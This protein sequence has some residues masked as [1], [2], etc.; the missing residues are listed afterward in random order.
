MPAERKTYSFSPEVRRLLEGSKLAFAAFQ[1]VDGQYVTLL[2]SDGAC[3]IFELGREE[4]MR[5]L[6]NKSYR[7]MHPNDAGKLMETSRKFS[8]AEELSVIFRVMR[9]GSYHPVLF[10]ERPQTMEDGSVLY[11]VSYTDMDEMKEGNVREYLAYQ[12]RQSQ[13]L[14]Q[15]DVT[16]LPNINYFQN[17]A[18]GTLRE[19]LDRGQQPLVIFL[20][21]QGMHSYNDRFGYEKGDLLLK[22]TAEIIRDSFPGDFCVRHTEDHIVLITVKKDYEE[23]INEVRRKVSIYASGFAD[24]VVDV[25]AG[26]YRYTDS[27]Q[28]CVAAVD[29]ARRA[30]DYIHDCPGVFICQYS[31]QVRDS[32]NRKDYVISHYREAMKKGWIRV[33][34]QPLISSKTG[35]VT[36][37]EAL[38]R[39]IDP[40]YGFLSPADFIPILEDARRL[41]EVDLY[42]LEN[43]CRSMRR[44]QDAG[45]PVVHTSFNL[46]RYDLGVEDLHER[47]NGI[48]ETYGIPRTLIAVEITESALTSHEEVIQR[49]IERFHADGYEVWLD[50]FGSGYSS[51][52]ALQKF[53]FDLLKIDMSFLRHENQRTPGILTSIVDLTKGLKIGSV[54]EGVETRQQY[55]FLKKIGCGMLQGFY[56]SKPVPEEQFLSV[57]KEKNLDIEQTPD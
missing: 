1:I 7:K 5:Y 20:D 56:F 21:V 47:I 3:G 17:F 43:I 49:H 23:R 25:K 4:L 28:S 11:F 35:K 2:V 18:P 54:T 16:D 51:F 6:T 36:H 31:D 40:V 22:E 46:S 41:W 50:D 32:Y 33:Y 48:L 26:V 10:H 9:K 52:S 15:D 30:V 29:K 34:Y 38:S 44:I 19:Y 53:D 27:S 55:D 39:W 37:C 14:Y 12:D 13:I 42:V 57:L 45:E 24:S 8:T